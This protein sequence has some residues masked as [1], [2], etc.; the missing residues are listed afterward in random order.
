MSM[1][2]EIEMIKFFILREGK[3][4]IGVF[5]D[6]DNDFYKIEEIEE[7]KAK[8]LIE[9]MEKYGY[10][11]E[12]ITFDAGFG[13]GMFDFAGL[14]IWQKNV[15]YIIADFLSQNATKEQTQKVK[16]GLIDK[17]KT[18]GVKFVVLVKGAKHQAFAVNGE[19]V[20][21]A[22]IPQKPRADLLK[23]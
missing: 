1:F 4:G 8:F 10:Q 18:F 17:A 9:L 5:E 13:L 2:E 16:K 11:S 22:V 23:T 7:I 6:E 15:P 20:H 21:P 3:G 14:I 12:E 19:M